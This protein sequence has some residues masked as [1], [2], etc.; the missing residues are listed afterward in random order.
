MAKRGVKVTSS[1]TEKKVEKATAVKPAVIKPAAAK[2]AA[3]KPAA[4]KTTKTTAKKEIKVRA[5]V[6][7][8]GK[9]VEEKDMI[10]NVKKAWIMEEE[11]RTSC[12]AGCSFPLLFRLKLL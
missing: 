9:Q 11:E 10:A 1:T 5:V 6:E 3:V 8:Y 12:R 2:P 4:K 7:Y